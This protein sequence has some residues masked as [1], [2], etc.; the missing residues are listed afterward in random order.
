MLG[1]NVAPGPR[2]NVCRHAWRCSNELNHKS[3][4]IKQ[5]NYVFS[6]TRSCSFSR[7]MLLF[8][9]LQPIPNCVR[10]NRECCRFDLT[11]AADSA[12]RSR[13]GKECQD[14]SR[15]PAIIPE[16]KMI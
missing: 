9:A 5:S 2:L 8:Q 4:R 14:C 11:G 6:E 12:S 15:R 7:Y 3:I 16:V 13:P 1:R 10:W